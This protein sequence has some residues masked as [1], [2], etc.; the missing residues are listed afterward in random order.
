MVRLALP[1]VLVTATVATAAQQPS[2]PPPIVLPLPPLMAPVAG[3]LTGGTP[4][5]PVDPTQAADDLYRLPPGQ[6]FR[7]S[8]HRSSVVSGGYFLPDVAPPSMPSASQRPVRPD[9]P[10]PAPSKPLEPA[11]PLPPPRLP[12]GPTRI[13][14]IPNCYAGNVPPRAERLPAGCDITRVRILDTP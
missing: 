5:P 7:S 6:P 14:V 2:G 3:G 8:S 9:P 1:I 13:Y 12:D 11:A 4:I 10:A